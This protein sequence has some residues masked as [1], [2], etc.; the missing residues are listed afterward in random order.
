VGPLLSERTGKERRFKMPEVCPVC[1][2]DVDHPPGEAMSRCTNAA[3]PAQVYERVRHFASRGAMDI[4]GLGDVMAQQLTELGL[5]RDIAD[6]YALD[7]DGLAQVPR[8]G[9][10]SRE[11]LLASVERSKRRG[12][13]RLLYGLGIRFVGSQTAQ[14]LAGDFGTID[15]I[16]AASEEELQRSEGIGPEVSASVALF[17]K[18]AANRKMIARLRAAGVDVTAPKRER[19]PLGALAGKTLVITG[20]LPTLTREEAMALI[21]A[22]GGK[23]TGSVSKRTDYVVAGDEPGSKLAKAGQLGVF[24]I[25]EEGLRTLLS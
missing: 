16:A 3:C 11:N 23:V 22:A 5:V 19:A 15:A 13:A 9:P 12:L 10:K 7:V 14:I 25:D 21:L 4:E 24:V 8:T 2:S 18:Q 6:V 20:T 1:G 17:F